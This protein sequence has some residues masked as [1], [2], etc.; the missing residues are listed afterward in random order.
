MAA[1]AMLADIQQTV[2]REEVTRELLV[3]VQCR[4]SLPVVDRRSNQLCY[5]AKKSGLC[6]VLH[7]EH[8]HNSMKSEAYVNV[9]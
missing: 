8:Q 1:L 2:Y 5:A 6:P 4:E 7:R 9:P 3:M